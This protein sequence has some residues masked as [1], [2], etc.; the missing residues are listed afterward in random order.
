MRKKGVL[1]IAAA[2]LLCAAP[3]AMAEK[4]TL[5]VVVKG[6]DNP[7][8]AAVAKGCKDWNEKNA[9]SDYECVSSGPEMSSDSAGQIQIVEKLIDSGAAAIAVAPSDPSAMARAILAKSP[10]MPIITYDTDFGIG[11]RY[12]R[13]TF[14]GTDNHEIGVLMAKL[15]MKYKPDGGT[16]CLQL[17]IKWNEKISARAQGFRD[18]IGGEPGT[19]RLEDTN[20]W[21][22]IA[23]C[24]VYSEERIDVAIDQMETIVDANPE[25]GA[26]IPVGG[27]AQFSAPAYAQ[28]A[29]KFRDRLDSR[30][31]V[32]IAGDTLPPQMAALKAGNSHGQIGQRPVELGQQAPDILIQLI[33][34]KEVDDPTYVGIDQCAPENADR[35]LTR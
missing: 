14:L 4:Q 26:F 10:S 27:W 6:L 11:H 29:S 16:V 8:F 35:C 22:E 15:L 13:K 21:S 30:K 9:K 20:G 24:P 1:L 5:A 34:E 3:P 7:F 33:R 28:L 18:A 2:A 12:L 25:L 19:G 17:G 31:L 32:V 23:G